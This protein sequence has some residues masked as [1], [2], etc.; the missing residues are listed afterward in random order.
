MAGHRL[1]H[2]NERVRQLLSAILVREIKDPRFQGVTITAVSLSKNLS[3]GK[4]LFSCFES[5]MDIAELMATLNKAAGY[6]SLQLGKS[7]TTRNT[8]KLQFYY[9]RGFDYAQEIERQ[10]AI[11][12]SQ[13]KSQED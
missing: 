12:S 9:D 10:L 3:F 8:P 11:I 6:F 5:G 2:L 1:E 4:V 13:P 7:M